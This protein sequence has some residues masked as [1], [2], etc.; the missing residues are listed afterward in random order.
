MTMPQARSVSPAEPAPQPGGAAR[1]RAFFAMQTVGA[2][3]FFWK[4]IPLYR[5]VLADPSKHHPR[6]SIMVWVLAAIVLIQ[7]GFWACYRLQPPVFRFT[8]SLFSQ[9]MLFLGRMAFVFA[10]TVFGFVF[11]A[12][13]PNY[14]AYGFQYLV[15]L[16][17]LFSL[18]CYTQEL[19]R[20]ARTLL[21]DDRR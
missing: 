2:L 7:L 8:N 12:N 17:G 6:E 16:A 13:K 10:S 19:E 15:I 18:Y 5:D 11:I 3:A 4:G 14:R 20:L 1:Y 21:P 9:A